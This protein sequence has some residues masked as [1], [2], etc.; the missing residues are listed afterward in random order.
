LIPAPNRLVSYYRSGATMRSRSV[1]NLV[2]TDTLDV[3]TPPAG[4]VANWQREI[5]TQL[6]LEPGDVEALALARARLRWPDYRQCVQAVADWL[7]KLG[8]DDLLPSSEVALMACRGAR[9]HHDA[10][11]YGGSVFCNLFLSDDKGLDLHF[12]ATGLRIPLARGTVVLFDTGQPHAV[13]ERDSSRFEAADFPLE[14][15]CTQVFLTWEL[16]VENA[17]IS[18]ALRVNFDIDP[19]SASVLA[20]EQVWLNGA[21]T[22]VCPAS[23]Q[24]RPGR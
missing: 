6:S 15:D 1:G 8:T 24:W 21:P 5:A 2:L 12:V 14:R 18:Q 3:P 20:Q 13:V 16:P 23:G 11:Q 10:A 9:Y 19:A 7:A 17:A 22:N 4:L